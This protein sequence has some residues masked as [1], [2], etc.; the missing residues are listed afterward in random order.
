MG[1]WVTSS[2]PFSPASLGLDQESRFL[3]WFDLMGVQRHLKAAGIF[4]RLALRDGKSDYL[5]YLPRTLGY[6]VEA[7]YRHGTLERLAGFVDERVMPSLAQ[8][9]I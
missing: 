7:G 2:S 1:R 4:A 9:G 3:R 6:V 8:R 5:R